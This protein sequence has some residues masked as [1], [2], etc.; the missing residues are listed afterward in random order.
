MS[1]SLGFSIAIKGSN[2]Q[3]STGLFPAFPNEIENSR[4]IPREYHRQIISVYFGPRRA[5]SLLSEII[6]HGNVG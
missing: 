4:L 1:M 6:H 5:I 2:T 3:F